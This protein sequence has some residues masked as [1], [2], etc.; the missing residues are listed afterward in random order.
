MIDKCINHL[1]D[2]GELIF[3]VP[4]SL[5]ADASR[6]KELRRKMVK[7]GAFT[8]VIFCHGQV[9]WE[10]AAVDTLI[11]RW[12]R[13]A[14]QKKVQTNLGPRAFFESNG[15]TWLVDFEPVGTLGEWFKATVGSAPSRLAVEN[16]GSGKYF[17][18]GKF[19]SIDES[20]RSSWPRVHDTPEGP[21][22]FFV[23]GPIRRWPVFFNGTTGK[24]LDN[25]L[26]P[27]KK[28]NTASA[29]IVL[30]EWFKANGEMLGL[31]KG[32]R[33]TCGVKQIENCPIDTTLLR[34]LT[35][36]LVT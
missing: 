31:I 11:F 18:E 5:F 23:G 4:S 26:L 29:A 2:G 8:D 28:L 27:K 30:N 36:I 10:T 20:D 1:E 7:L 3:I 13:G 25:A 16:G 9:D 17:K 15:F 32:G 14:V 12:E 33:W 6:G 35:E 34:D 21:K 24:H 22:L 19:I